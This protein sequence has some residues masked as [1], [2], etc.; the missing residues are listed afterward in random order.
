MT[1]C[2]LQRF[3]QTVP[4]R[5]QAELSAGTQRGDIYQSYGDAG[6]IATQISD[7]LGVTS[8]AI[9]NHGQCVHSNLGV[10]NHSVAVSAAFQLDM[11][12]HPCAPVRPSGPALSS[13]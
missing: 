10:E 8:K 13:A 1:A 12:D 2:A 6:P 11:V 7:R 5:E 4:T 3:S 9:E